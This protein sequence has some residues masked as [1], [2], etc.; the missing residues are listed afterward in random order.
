VHDKHLHINQK[1]DKN[2]LEPSIPADDA[3]ASMHTMLDAEMTSPPSNKPNPKWGGGN[4]FGTFFIS[5]LFVASFLFLWVNKKEFNKME[6]T[7][8]LNNSS[9]LKKYN[10]KKL[11]NFNKRVETNSANTQKDSVKSGSI[12]DL[13]IKNKK[14]L[15]N[16]NLNNASSNTKNVFD[17]KKNKSSENENDEESTTNNTFKEKNILKKINIIIFQKQ[18]MIT[19]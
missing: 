3:W 9:L 14:Y 18:K 11:Y 7:S 1:L 13:Y 5:T 17:I 12:S 8:T 2:Y 4:H 16:N 6:R 10:E 19:I 15:K